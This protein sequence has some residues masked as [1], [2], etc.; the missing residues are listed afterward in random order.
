[1]RIRKLQNWANVASLAMA[2]GFPVGAAQ[3]SAATSRIQMHDIELFSYD[4]A[5]VSIK[6][7]DGKLLPVETGKTVDLN[8]VDSYRIHMQAADVLL[9]ARTLTILMNRY[10]LPRAQ[11]PLSD[12]RLSF[13]NGVIHLRGKIRAVGMKLGFTADAVA[14]VTPDGDM[15]MRIEHLKTAGFIPGSV[16]N[17]LGM[18]LERMAKPHRSGVMTVSGNAMTVPIASTFPPPLIDGRL[19]AVK[20]TPNGLETIIGPS[21]ANGG[22]PFIRISGGPVRF[23]HLLMPE[24]KLIIRPGQPKRDF[25]FSPRHYYEQMAAGTSKATPDYALIGLFRDYRRLSSGSGKR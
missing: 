3:A 11:S 21:R 13:G 12:L 6:N 20:V 9:S 19:R 22:T 5:S 24:A 2:I 15:G 1:M 4:D 8:N 14:F 16:S 7:L 18:T 23:A 17:A 10:V 25:G